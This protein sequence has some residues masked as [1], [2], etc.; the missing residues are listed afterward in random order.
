M[1]QIIKLMP[2]EEINE[3]LEWEYGDLKTRGPYPILEK[4]DK[5]RDTARA[6]HKLAAQ[7][8]KLLTAIDEGL[9]LDDVDLAVRTVEEL[10]ESSSTEAAYQCGFADGVNKAHQDIEDKHFGQP[11]YGHGEDK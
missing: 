2:V 6:A 11:H 7:L 1:T 3:M 5:L 9:G 4:R 10:Y 8:Q